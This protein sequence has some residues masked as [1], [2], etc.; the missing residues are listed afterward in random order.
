[1]IGGRWMR[2][3]FFLPCIAAKTRYILVKTELKDL[4]EP[5]LFET[6]T[7]NARDETTIGKSAARSQVNDNDYQQLSPMNQLEA[8]T[9]PP[10]PVDASALSIKNEIFPLFMSMLEDFQKHNMTSSSNLEPV[11]VGMPSLVNQTEVV[12]PTTM[13]TT[14]TTT[15]APVVIAEAPQ[16]DGVT[17]VV[18]AMTP[19]HK[20]LEVKKIVAFT[21][22]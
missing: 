20:K 3:I 6:R 10:Q 7:G 15:P 4:D 14:T 8:S 1:M 18:K 11:N 17:R 9:L 22:I 5:N 21:F 12:I 13:T 19:I 2:L 16:P